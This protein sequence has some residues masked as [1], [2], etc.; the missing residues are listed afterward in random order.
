MIFHGDQE[1]GGE[2]RE[3]TKGFSFGLGVV[4]MA[5][6]FGIYLAYPL[7]PFLPISTTAKVAVAVVGSVASWSIFFVGSLLAGRAGRVYLRRFFK[8]GVRLE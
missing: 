6:S 3:S 7:I 2:N 5:L 8:L 4:L 1:S